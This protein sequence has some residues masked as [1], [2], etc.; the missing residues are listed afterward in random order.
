MTLLETVQSIAPRAGW[1]AETDEKFIRASDGS[2]YRYSPVLDAWF[3]GIGSH[4]EY[5]TE[6]QVKEWIEDLAACVNDA[7]VGISN[8]TADN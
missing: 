4:E 5:A 3:Y 7:I 2:F 6:K 8:G 1:N